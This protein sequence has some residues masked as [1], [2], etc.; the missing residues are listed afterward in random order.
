MAEQLSNRIHT[1]LNGGID[2]SVTTLT[3]AS[4]TGFPASGNFRI[5]IDNEIITVGARSG[6]T[7]SSLTRAS[8]AIDGA[9]TAASH[10]DGAVV[11]LVLTAGALTARESDHT[12]AAD[13][14][15]GYVLESLFDAK[16]DILAA[17]ADNTPAK[18]TVGTNNYVLT[19]AS[20]ETTG[21][22]WAPSTGTGGAVDLLAGHTT[23]EIKAW[24]PLLANDIDLDAAN[25]WWRKVGTPSTAPTFVDVTGESITETYKYCIKTVAAAASDGM[26]Q[27]YTYADEPRLKTGRTVSLALAIW[28]VSSVSVTASLLN[29]DATHT[30]ASAVTAA[31][32]T[33]V[34]IEGHVL[35]GT[36]CDLKVTAGAAG[37]FYVVPLG[38]RVG[39][40]A[41]SL[42]SRPT[43]WVYPDT[44]SQP[45]SLT[46]IGD[47]VTWTDVDCTSVTSNLTLRIVLGSYLFDNADHFLLAVRRNGSSGNGDVINEV[48][49]SVQVQINHFPMI[50]DDSQIFE[51]FL[52]RTS[53]SSTVNNGY[54]SVFAY[55]EWA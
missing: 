11:R 15:T 53:G 42:P 31:A 14:H 50:L 38:L 35:A 19:A 26:K 27:T 48:F 10:S 29:S 28:S 54:F 4:G 25:H 36:S 46:G 22:K 47:E 6:T 37:T 39:S 45:K 51:Y 49:A 33:I 2:N 32:W 43:R 41:M 24:P 8:E 5:R 7:M 23:N 18:L 3:V 21:L 52:D 40:F 20:G 44:V 55:E 1:T 9:T 12:G 34:T 17:S 13:P 16:G 30:D